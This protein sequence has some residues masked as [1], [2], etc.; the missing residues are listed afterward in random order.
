MEFWQVFNT[1]LCIVYGLIGIVVGF[2]C[3]EN[4]VHCFTSLDIKSAFTMISKEKDI[5]Q[6]Y[7]KDRELHSLNPERNG[8]VPIDDIITADG[9]NQ[10]RHLITA[11]E[12][13]PGPSI[14]IYAN[15]KITILVKNHMINEAVTVHWHGIDQLRWPAMDGVA[16]VS[17][18]PILPG[19]TFNYTFQPTFGGSYWYHSHVGNQRDM[20]MY[21]A[22]IVL[23]KRDPVPFELQHI[24]QI[25]E[26]NHLYNAMDM[27]YANV[28]KE[29]KFPNSILINGRG[30]FKDNLAP[31]EIFYVTK[32]DRCLFR[33]IGVGSMHV[34]LFSIPGLKLNVTETDGF[35]VVPTVVDQLIIYPAERY[36]FELDLNYAEEGIYNITV[37]ILSSY[38]LTIKP[39]IGLGFLNV[40]NSRNIT[41]KVYENNIKS[42]VLNC[43]FKTFPHEE[44]IVCVPVSNLKSRKNVDDEKFVL[45]DIQNSSETALH[46][47]NFGFPKGDS[48][49]NGRIFR[50]PTV[51]ALT[52]PSEV[53]TV[54]SGCTDEETCHCSHSIN[55]R[56][57]SEIIMVLLN[58]GTGAAISHPIH[59]H[60]HTYKVLKMEFPEVT[61]D[62]KFNFTEDIE[63]SSTLPNMNSSCNNARWRNSSWNDYKN[64]P[65]ININDPVRKD[66]IVV[67]YGGYVIIRIEAK[68]PG[69]WFMHC[70]ID[71]HMVEGMALMLNESFENSRLEIPNGLPT[72]HSYLTKMSG[73]VSSISTAQT[74]SSDSTNIL[75]AVVGILGV[76]VLLLFGYIIWKK[77]TGSTASNNIEM[78][79][80]ST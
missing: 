17:Q 11:N 28:K 34:L 31:L 20:G 74:S 12:S 70:H 21:G 54:C 75:Y 68:N 3:D 57:G 33:L 14:I 40:S 42:R 77:R 19:Q 76:V 67:P 39:Y 32:G 73:V 16:F 22:F 49:I 36:D 26:W 7:A 62:G 23:R 51:S 8:Q 2:Q 72:C 61:I 37:S 1:L 65:G 55:L 6:V 59:M 10:T 5:G 41:S 80:P 9:W 27:L 66:T 15:Q 13:M 60:G 4:A 56:S 44:D 52:Q 58:L 47:L 43:P 24:V 29:V 30:E 35:E 45:Q 25:Q 78:Q 63:C 79:P 38:N 46:F 48:S 18:C 53:D 69:V 50:W 71:E 64:I